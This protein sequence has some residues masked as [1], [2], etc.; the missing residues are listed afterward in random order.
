MMNEA[1]KPPYI[2]RATD[3][4][5]CCIRGRP[6]SHTGCKHAAQTDRSPLDSVA[7]EPRSLLSRSRSRRQHA[8]V[9][10]HSSQQIALPSSSRQQ[11]R[12]YPQVELRLRRKDQKHHQPAVPFGQHAKLVRSSSSTIP[13]TIFWV[14][15]PM[16]H[17]HKQAGIHPRISQISRVRTAA[18]SQA[19][20]HQWQCPPVGKL[21]L[22]PVV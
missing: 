7:P 11:P 1:D 6:S 15:V 3:R 19:V 14:V 13:S 4:V 10:L 8:R 12:K 5:P 9:V 17:C 2:P 22:S 20:A 18:A 16:L 21:T